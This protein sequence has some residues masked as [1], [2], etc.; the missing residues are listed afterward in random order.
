VLFRSGAQAGIN[1][2]FY[3]AP[4]WSVKT[5]AGV[6]FYNAEASLAHAATFRNTQGVLQ[7]NYTYN[8]YKE[9]PSLTLLTVP[10]MV[11][12]ETG[13]KTA[14][15]AALGA[16]IGI[17]VSAEYKTTGQLKTTGYNT[18]LMVTYDN[19]PDYGFGEFDVNQTTDWDLN[20]S[21]QLSVEAGAKWRFTDKLSLYSGV[22]FDYGLTNLNKKPEDAGTRLITWQPGNPGEFIYGGL[23][24]N[25]DKLYP[26]NVGITLR[27]SFGLGS[28]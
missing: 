28:F 25:S 11:Q 12:G 23:F 14:F 13:G 7:F 10:V 4:S 21:V 18:E 20:L 24:N 16:K 8:N 6:A 1:Y 26:V 22:Y 5:G 3:F 17:P 9:S 15:Y 27:L 2:N 19:L